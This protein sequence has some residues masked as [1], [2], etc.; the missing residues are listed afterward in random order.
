LC[1]F[2]RNFDRP[3]AMKIHSLVIIALLEFLGTSVYSQVSTNSVSEILVHKLGPNI[4]SKADEYGAYLSRNGLRMYFAT[5]RGS[6]KTHIYMSKRKALDSAWG[7]A[8]YVKI[9]TNPQDFVGAIAFDD[10]GRFYFA[11]NR[12][13]STNGDVNLWEGFG[14]DS[15]PTIRVLPNPVNT[16]KWETQPSVTRD[17]SDLYFASNRQS[18]MGSLETL[19]DLYVSHRNSDGSWSDPQNLGS[20]IN[21]GIY[22]GTPFISPDGHF[23]FFCSKEKR[24][25]DIKRKIYMSERIGPK[26]TDW[27]KPVLLPSPINSDKDDIF[28]MI[29]SDGKTIFFSSNRDGGSGLDI[30]EATLPEDIQNKIFHSF[31]GY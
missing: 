14:I 6:N 7:E 5:N 19:I 9:S 10:I 15:V 28:P 27:S 20:Q 3:T 2:I 23:L 25:I 18:P 4:N 24:G 26:Y 22:N 21:M 17:G 31:P 1:C 12:Q 11:T 13:S 29:A 8:E 16:I 30:Y